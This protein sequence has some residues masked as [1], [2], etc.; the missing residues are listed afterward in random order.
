M[1][2]NSPGIADHLS[3]ISK[4][5]GCGGERGLNAGGACF[6]V[7]DATGTRRV[8]RGHN[9]AGWWLVTSSKIYR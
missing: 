5:V 9:G 6:G 2:K 1:S 3:R 7:E 8:T 4:S